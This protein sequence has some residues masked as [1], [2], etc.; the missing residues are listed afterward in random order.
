MLDAIAELAITA[1]QN[2]RRD[3]M[4][5]MLRRL[6]A[7]MADP[8]GGRL[9]LAA[10]AHLEYALGRAGDERGEDLPTRA[11][12]LTTAGNL[13]R[14]LASLPDEHRTS[15]WRERQAWSVI[16]YAGNLRKQS[17]FEDALMEAAT[18][19]G[20][21]TDLDNPYGRSYS[22]FMIGF[23][24][25][26]LGDFEQAWGFLDKAH[27][28]AAEHS[29]E[30]FRVDFLMQMGEVR[31]CQGRVGEARGLLGESL[32]R[33]ESLDLALTGAFAKVALGAVEYQ[34]VRLSEAQ[35]A[36]E[37]ARQVF[38]KCAH[39]EGTALSA[40]RQATVERHSAE[41]RGARSY[42]GVIRL[43]KTARGLYEKME[44]PAGVAACDIEQ[45]RV[46]IRRKPEDVAATLE[47]LT[48]LL[49]DRDELEAI[50]LDPWV[51]RVLGAFAD[52]VGDVKFRDR[53]Q[54][55][56]LSAEKLLAKRAEQGI[57]QVKLVVTGISGRLDGGH[58]AG[59]RADEMGGETRRER[60]GLAVAPT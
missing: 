49:D 27:R 9:E 46:A 29:F 36:L 12:R 7:F 6:E 10:V 42:R 13:Y 33:A 24:L 52:E 28:L 25:R 47:A 45:G 59:N 56:R 44:S 40:R 26:L 1:R 57:A 37:E 15:A 30:R 50:E 41:S 39:S 8:P 22:L 14:Q 17:N 23:C 51:P 4:T 34:E 19:L 31:R 55:V 5:E 16:S 11:S 18:A 21:F 53:A 58:G 35:T 60:S 38:E 3:L 2:R 32:A 48:A 54:T 43:I 20:H